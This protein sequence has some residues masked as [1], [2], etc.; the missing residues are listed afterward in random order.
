LP[1]TDFLLHDGRQQE[2]IHLHTTREGEAQA[3]QEK[4]GGFN[5]R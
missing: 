5:P 3:T 1:L 4:G 2:D